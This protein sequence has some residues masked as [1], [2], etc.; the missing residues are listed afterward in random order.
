MSSRLGK[1]F[2]MMLLCFSKGMQAQ[3][4]LLEKEYLYLDSIMQVNYNNRQAELA[5]LFKLHP[6]KQDSLRQVVQAVFG[7]MLAD[8]IKLAMRY[9]ST[10]SGLQRLYWTR[11]YVAKD[12]LSAI[13]DT[14]SVEMQ[15]SFYGQ[16]L[17]EYIRV[18][19]IEEGDMLHEF[20]CVQADSTDFDWQ[21]VKGKQVL[22]LFG[23]LGCMGADGR[24][25][26]AKLHS[27]TDRSELEVIVYWPCE[28][29]EELR[30]LQQQYPSEYVFVSDF[31]QDASPM[32]IRYGAQA[33]PTCFLTD[34]EHRIE[35]KCVGLNTAL[36]DK[37]ISRKR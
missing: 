24:E 6:E 3:H 29:L 17:G 7:K 22:L 34:K 25:R 32:S 12:T 9:A 10:P 23:G 11:L 16:N 2:L 33:T 13:F 28:S 35:V 18:E 5:N 21:T 15:Q 30:N 31:K 4:M 27:E 8:N 1:A 37:H 14:L 26:L 19:Q 20:P 36:F